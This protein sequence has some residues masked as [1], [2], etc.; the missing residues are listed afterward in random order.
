ML[1]TALLCYFMALFELV[2]WLTD[3][4]PY[5]NRGAWKFFKEEDGKVV[6][7][8][9]SRNVFFILAMVNAVPLFLAGLCAQ[10]RSKWWMIPFAGL[11]AF[12]TFQQT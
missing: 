7:S 3:Y 1:T 10:R 12:F 5:F 6:G 11:L 2:V 9:I 4:P 8:D